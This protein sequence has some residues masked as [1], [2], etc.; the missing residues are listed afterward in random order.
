MHARAGDRLVA[1]HQVFALAEAVQENRHRADVEPVRAEPHQVIQDARDLVEHHADVLR[2]DRR[3]DAEQLLDREHVS[4]LVAHHRHVVETIHVADRLV[5]R[6]A[7]G[8]LFGRA[9]QQPDM[10]VGLLHDLAVHLEHEAQH[11]VRRRVLRPE[12]HR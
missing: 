5:V 12:V 10:R 7:L 11:A 1:V 6:L 8:E 2:A 9:V 4:V 3:L